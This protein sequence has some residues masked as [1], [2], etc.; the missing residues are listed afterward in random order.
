MS[1]D[2]NVTQWTAVVQSIQQFTRNW[3]S[4]GDTPTGA[5]VRGGSETTQRIFA[6]DRTGRER[7]FN[8]PSSFAV[9]EGQTLRATYAAVGKRDP[10][11]VVVDVLES[12]Q[13][14]W[15]GNLNKLLPRYWPVV[16]VFVILTPLAL[17]GFSEAYD[18][19]V[20]QP[21][22]TEQYVRS[23][24]RPDE[25]EAASKACQARDRCRPPNDCKAVAKECNDL[26]AS[27]ATFARIRAIGEL[28]DSRLSYINGLGIASL[29]MLAA[30]LVWVRT[31][32]AKL[33]ATLYAYINQA[34]NRQQ[35]GD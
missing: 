31:R 34:R 10:I 16:L 14:W 1:S 28:Q 23:F 20:I 32:R 9:R 25:V 18:H 27:N 35:M 26:S 8:A 21:Q 29:A 30:G 33:L 17:K 6:R 2:V 22:M 19:I 3:V 5:I 7:V 4:G 11:L 15:D 24:I 13:H 12:G